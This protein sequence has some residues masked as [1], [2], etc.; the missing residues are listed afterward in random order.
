MTTAVSS[1]L[2]ALTDLADWHQRVRA[3]FPILIAN[4]GIGYLDSAATAQKPQA[5]LDRVMSYLTTANANA[6]RGAYPW[7][8]TTTAAI[9]ETKRSVRALLGDSG[10]TSSV[11][12]VSGASEGLR[13]V[14]DWLKPT[15]RDG[16]RIVVPF[17]DHV[18]NLR[19]WL[20]LAAD[21]AASGVRIDVA[22]LPVDPASGDYAH[23]EFPAVFGPSTRLVAATGVHHVYGA[24]LNVQRIRAAV[25]PGVPICLDAAQSVGHR[26][27][28][29]DD[30]DV[31]FIVFSGHKM[32]AL[33]GTGAVWAGNRRGPQFTLAG[34]PGTPN[35]VGAISLTAAAQWL[36]D[37]GVTSIQ[38]WCTALC[39]LLTDGL[40][41][42]PEVTVLGCQDS[43]AAS[44]TV[45]RRESL[46]TFRH[47]RVRSDDLGFALTAAGLLTR[48]DTHCQAGRD[49]QDHA[50]RVS[51]HAYT[52]PEEIHRLLDIVGQA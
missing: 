1:T 44:S 52:S 39:A 37:T 41:R 49:S 17:H 10:T 35:T 20:D 26:P 51:V 36:A 8:T 30:L 18:A 2:D 19:P 15:L 7:A 31:D 48:Y 5:V 4:P 3:Q 13:R 29:V 45:Q 12:L 43:L 23:R 9:E 34:W 50:V 32:M 14:A 24:D 42:L 27:V 38:R 11:E 33:P 22:P 47:R 21:L 25:G 6:G 46:V 28:L 16:D 40:A